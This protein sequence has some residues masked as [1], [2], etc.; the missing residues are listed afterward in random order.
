MSLDITDRKAARDQLRSLATHDP[1]TQLL[2]RRELLV[3]MS[4]MLAHGRRGRSRMAVLVADLAHFVPDK[5]DTAQPLPRSLHP[6]THHSAF[7]TFTR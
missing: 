2:N 4:M 5:P 6:H 1:L 7:P 3:R